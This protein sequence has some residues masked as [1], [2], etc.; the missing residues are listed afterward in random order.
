MRRG[1]R[2]G[3]FLAH[4]WGVLTLDLQITIDYLLR[5]TPLILHLRICNLNKFQK[6]SFVTPCAARIRQRVWRIISLAFRMYVKRTGPKSRQKT[7]TAPAAFE[8]AIFYMLFKVWTTIK[9]I[10]ET[11]RKYYFY[12]FYRRSPRPDYVLTHR[13]PFIHRTFVLAYRTPTIHIRI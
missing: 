8:T 6:H 10:S 7:F 13:I 4:R 5:P 3:P 11:F 1:T 12:T 2:N 9:S